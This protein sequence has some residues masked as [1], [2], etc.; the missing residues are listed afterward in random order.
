MWLEVIHDLL[1]R[2]MVLLLISFERLELLQELFDL[3]SKALEYLH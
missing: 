2:I 1:Y 3:L